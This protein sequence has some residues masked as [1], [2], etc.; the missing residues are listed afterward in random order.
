MMASFVVY[1]AGSFFLTLFGF[2]CVDVFVSISPQNVFFTILSAAHGGVVR[3]GSWTWMECVL[4]MAG[5][6]EVIYTRQF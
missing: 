2:L 1:T 6:K 3:V 5:R 4:L